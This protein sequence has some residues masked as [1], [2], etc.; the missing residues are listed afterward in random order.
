MLFFIVNRKFKK[1]KVNPKLKDKLE[2]L[3]PNKSSCSKEE[4]SFN[5][6]CEIITYISK[7]SYSLYGDD[8]NFIEFGIRLMRLRFSSRENKVMQLLKKEGILIPFSSKSSKESYVTKFGVNEKGEKYIKSPGICKKYSLNSLYSYTNYIYNISKLNNNIKILPLL[9]TEGETLEYVS[10]KKRKSNKIYTKIESQMYKD[11]LD[12]V[13]NLQIDYKIIEKQIKNKIEDLN[14]SRFKCDNKIKAEK[15]E[16]MFLTSGTVK[17]ITK[18]KAQSIANY[19]HETLIQDGKN[20][21]IGG[22]EQFLEYKK[23]N[24]YLSYTD[25]IERLK[26]G[27]L[28][29]KRN[30]TNGRLD[31]NFTNMPSFILKEIMKQNDLVQIDLANSQFAILSHMMEKEGY[32]TKDFNLFKNAAYNGTLYDEAMKLVGD[33]CRKDTKTTF[34]ESLFSKNN[35]KSKRKEKLLNKYPTVGEYITKIKNKKTY[36]DFSIGLQREESKIFIDNL[37]PRIK[38]EIET[39]I[40]KHDAFI[41]KRDKIEKVM[42]IIDDY[43]KEINFKGKMIVEL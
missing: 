4:R 35:S 1:L 8:L 7:K 39:V 13:D 17:W 10:V 23:R 16:V 33:D 15:F 31:T 28:Y 43:F 37:Y 19:N 5:I 21:Y 22:K 40:T 3:F 30:K 25:S 34:F 29:A 41:I 11:F 6:A 36:K 38:K 14:I 12:I 27:D 18:K 26:T 42:N 32:D 24:L 2:S 9:C 20:F